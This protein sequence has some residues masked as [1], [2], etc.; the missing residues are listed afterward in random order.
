MDI[1]YD[2]IS[3]AL[4]IT[5]YWSQSPKAGGWT[6]DIYKDEKG[7]HKVEVGILALEGPLEPEELSAGGFLA[8]VG[9]DKELRM[10]RIPPLNEI[11]LFTI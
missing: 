11:S 10:C 2:S 3:Y 5:A 8:V 4:T 6:E 9:E 1:D 7:T